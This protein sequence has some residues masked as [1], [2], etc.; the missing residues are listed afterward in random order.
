MGLPAAGPPAG[1]DG[2]PNPTAPA[3]PAQAVPA[4]AAPAEQIRRTN[5]RAGLTSFVGRDDDVE[6]V[7]ALTASS[8]LTTLTGPGGAGKTRLAVEAAR[9]LLDEVPDGVWLVE[10]A[11]VAEPADVARTALAVLGLRGQALLAGSR[12]RVSAAEA[13]AEPLDRLLAALADKSLL[14]VLDNCEHLVE[15]AAQLADRVLGECPH[16]RILATS[17]EPLRIT[18]ERLWPVRPLALPPAGAGADDAAG[19]AAVRLFAD[20]AAALRPGFAVDA[21]NGPA[22]IRI[23]QALDGI[24]LAIEL[25]A[26]R[27]RAMTPEA[28]AARLDDRFRLLTGGSRTALPRHRTLAAVVDWSWDLLDGAERALL[29]RLAVFTGGVT[30]EAAEAVCA[31]D[32]VAARDVPDLLA[33]LVEKSLMVAADSD[34]ARPRYRLLETIRAYGLDKLAAAGERERL[35]RVHAAYFLALAEAAEPHL[36]GREQLEWLARIADDHD[37]IH[38]ALRGAIAASDAGT[39]LRLVVALGWYWS[40][41]GHRAEAVA[42]SG[43][44]LALADDDGDRDADGDCDADADRDRDADGDRGLDD[45]ALRRVRAGAY[46]VRAF[47]AFGVT[48]DIAG[49]L[50]PFR[51][52]EDAA[53]GLRGGHPLLRLVGPF[54]V[55]FEHLGEERGLVGFT[56]RFDDPD[57][58]VAAMAR[59]M[60]GFG[61]VNLGRRHAEAEA[62]YRAALAAFRDLGERLGT[63]TCLAG[64]AELALQRGDHAFAV[65]CCEQARTLTAELG[66]ADELAH[67]HAMYAFALHLQ[68]RKEEATALLA[69]ARHAAERAGAPEGLA[70]IDFAQGELARVDGDPAGARALLLQAAVH[71]Q[72][73]GVS[74]QFH[75]M[76]AS[77][78]G[79]LDA[80]AGDL[81]A[82]RTRHTEAI[83]AALSSSDGPVIARVLVGVADL[84]LR[85]G[86]AARAATLLGAS[87]AVRGVPDRSLLDEPRVAAGARAA[88]GEPAFAEAFGRGRAETATTVRALC[89]VRW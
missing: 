81:D 79:Y 1:L 73:P 47:N 62:D 32:P 67:F 35:R 13:P 15:A 46:A 49:V 2:R 23:C 80:A 21:R 33:D 74:P 64:L 36:R 20:R 31:G 59:T 7:R 55:F 34:E 51:A 10:L 22:V 28:V 71:A 3:V 65:E 40:L 72:P 77:S 4:Q 70:A 76:I 50:S 27:L 5:L 39:A 85:A 84:A 69:E 53:A 43:A 29:S 25:A 48:S 58:W 17:R 6:G 56:D 41:R 60:H 12:M 68:G 37:N 82:A 8:R 83:D 24:P 19:Y 38:S 14:F 11:P 75:A 45:E 86:D 16:V 54:L 87:L 52:A 78:L 61:T 9:S 63:S 30:A 89:D 44:A 42:L 66:A 26:A 18:G 88:L 57:P